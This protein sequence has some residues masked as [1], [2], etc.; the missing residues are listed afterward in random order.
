MKFF[1]QTRFVKLLLLH[2]GAAIILIA[3]SK[4]RFIR[5]TNEYTLVDNFTAFVQSELK[6][7]VEFNKSIF[8]VNENHL[9]CYINSSDSTLYL[10]KDFGRN[11]I[12]DIFYETWNQNLYLVLICDPNASIKSR[13]AYYTLY[14]TFFDAGRR[15]LNDR[16][17]EKFGKDIMEIGMDK[18]RSLG[19]AGIPF[20]FHT[21]EIT[22]SKYLQ[23]VEEDFHKGLWD[24]NIPM[25]LIPDH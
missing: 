19:L 7:N 6:I 1:K 3:C 11:E 21:V 23:W 18:R 17:K 4:Y 5:Q 2:L 22:D 10:N 13:E 25:D 24:R 15:L 16:A 8:P 14:A 20:Y 12:E 9:L